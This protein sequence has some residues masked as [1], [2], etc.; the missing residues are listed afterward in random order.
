MANSNRFKQSDAINK[1]SAPSVQPG[2]FSRR[3]ILKLLPGFI[4]MEGAMS[5][6]APASMITGNSERVVVPASKDVLN[7]P[8][9]KLSLLTGHRL[10]LRQVMQYLFS[11]GFS[12]EEQLV[13]GTAIAIA[14]SGLYVAARNWH[15]EKGYRPTTDIISVKGP[16]EVWRDGRQLHS[17]RGVWQ[18]ASYWHSYYADSE[19]DDP[20]RAAAIAYQL[21]AG[22]TDFNLWTSFVYGSAQQHFDQSYQGWPALRPLVKRFLAYQGSRP[23]SINNSSVSDPIDKS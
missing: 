14:E 19:T 12:S 1:I 4:C 16:A 2:K 21:S 8:R 5:T 9:S 23:A 7:L 3:S 6:L 17:D 18:V 15:P 13:A 11:A 20:A 10:Q 22:G